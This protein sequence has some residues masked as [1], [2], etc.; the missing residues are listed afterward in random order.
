MC[1]NA[2]A[3]IRAIEESYD[4][5]PNVIKVYEPSDYGRDL[6][7]II[8]VYDK[9]EA[10]IRKVNAD[11]TTAIFREGIIWNDPSRWE[12]ADMCGMDRR[13]CRIA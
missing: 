9:S 1:R 3:Q 6:L 8:E 13:F 10:V 5:T 11:G 4:R 2:R 12:I 7:A